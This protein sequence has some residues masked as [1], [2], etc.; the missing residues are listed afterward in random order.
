M[1]VTTHLQHEFELLTMKMP[2]F[3]VK[4]VKP[5]YGAKKSTSASSKRTTASCIGST[6][7][8]MMFFQAGCTVVVLG[9]VK[10]VIVTQMKSNC[11]WE[12]VM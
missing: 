6:I 7:I 5:Q 12:V 9:Q 10:H 8:C 11:M 4:C 1:G 2:S 3:R